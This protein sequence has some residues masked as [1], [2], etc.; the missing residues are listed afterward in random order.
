MDRVALGATVQRAAKSQAMTMQV[1][2][3]PYQKTVT[4]S[5]A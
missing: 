5:R 4:I 1:H 3:E 2:T